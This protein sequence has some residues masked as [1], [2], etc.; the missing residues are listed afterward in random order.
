MALLMQDKTQLRLNQNSLLQIK[1][2]RRAG[3]R[4]AGTAAAGAPG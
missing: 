2:R 1:E 3:R 4:R